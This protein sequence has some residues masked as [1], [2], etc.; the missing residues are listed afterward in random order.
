MSENIFEDIT[1][2]SRSNIM[3]K[4]IY[5]NCST[6]KTGLF[7]GARKK[8]KIGELINKCRIPRSEIMYA[9]QYRG[10]TRDNEGDIIR[11]IF[12]IDIKYTD[13]KPTREEIEKYEKY[14]RNKL[15]NIFVDGEI[16]VATNHR[17]N[18]ISFHY[19]VS[20]YRTTCRDLLNLCEEMEDDKIDKTI[21]KGANKLMRIANQYKLG[22]KG[23]PE[24]E[25]KLEKYILNYVEE[26]YKVYENKKEKEIKKKGNIIIKSNNEIKKDYKYFYD[27]REIEE[28]LDRL[29]KKYIEEFEEWFKI[30]GILKSENLYEIWNEWSKKSKCYDE[31]KN[32]KIWNSIKPNININHL[33]YINNKENG[34]SKNDFE[35]MKK[36]EPI[37]RKIECNIKE[38]EESKI[39]PD[40]FNK[41]ETIIM[42]SDT[43]TGKTTNFI[44]NYYMN[45]SNKYRLLSIVS[46][47]S[48]ADDQYRAFNDMIIDY[49]TG[50][51]I[52]IGAQHY[53]QT[54]REEIGK[55]LICQVDS[56]MKYFD[57]GD[58]E[59]IK[60]YV[61]YMDE[62]NS[63]ITYMIQS[64]TLKGKRMEIFS[65]LRYIIK[66]CYKVVGTDADI[67]DLVFEF[68]KIRKDEGKI[69]IINKYKNYKGLKAY[70]IE[71]EER[72]YE[73]IKKDIIEGKYFLMCFDSKKKQEIV[74]NKIM[75]EY[76]SI[77]KVD[78]VE[79]F[80][81]INS[82]TSYD[83][84]K[85]NTE[86]WKNKY[87][88]YS[89]SI[90]YGCDFNIEKAQNVYCIFTNNSINPLG[91][92]Q[93]MTRTRNINNVYYH[94]SDYKR[95]ENEYES[96]EECDKKIRENIEMHKMFLQE[97][98]S[99]TINKEERYEILESDYYEM[100]KIYMYQRDILETNYKR[101]FEE[102]LLKKGF[103]I[104]KNEECDK[105]II[106]NKEMKQEIN[107]IKNEI[108]EEKEELYKKYIEYEE[109]REISEKE[110]IY[111]E[112]Y[113]KK[114]KILN[115][116]KIILKENEIMRKYIINDGE[117]LN[118]I[119]GV[120]IFYTEEK[121]KNEIT[122]K[123]KVDFAV[124]MMNN[125]EK[126]III[127]REIEKASGINLYNIEK[128]K[129]RYNEKV[130]IKEEI[131]KQ[132]KEIYRDRS[133]EIKIGT[134]EEVCK[135]IYKT[136]NK[137]Y[138]NMI[139]KTKKQILVNK[140]IKHYNEYKINKETVKEMYGI[141]K[142]RFNIRNVDKTVIEFL[143]EDYSKYEIL[144]DFIDE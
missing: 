122:N 32:M 31:E 114:R 76:K 107:E 140:K 69:Y 143:D 55:V 5:Y 87:I 1:N 34:E 92:I 96:I 43:N 81:M 45:E 54:K 71:K 110:K 120:K 27:K 19:V 28:I 70:D 126:K 141:W 134:V 73:I 99:I 24:L 11:P 52:N 124:N 103:I 64:N 68:L 57:K 33:V 109:E 44:R 131:V 42:R 58:I 66:N 79:N 21:Y 29:P 106:V 41:Y 78:K 12:D 59:E 51:R 138:S 113:E 102:I 6:V 18:K 23:R 90:V 91:M 132:Y 72:L 135:L 101:H 112:K 62:I 129:E 137:I 3:D 49:K 75:K 38:I 139:D 60:D 16:N 118:H 116:D 94:F 133:R 84:S 22:T 100:Y 128:Q 36:Y 56:L 15:R 30:T 119:N 121:I 40:N 48:L 130:I 46:R 74:Y 17:E 53:N 97:I 115:I 37:M 9:E 93:Q 61:V 8:I 14:Y 86:N 25:N 39:D 88:F 65:L 144:D 26:E 47:V 117:F 142:Y 85:T 98:C 20:N 95:K 10:C 123:C 67:S 7:F 105:K 13:R 127:L 89:P 80:I 136:Y 104:E 83:K 108:E 2:K 82:D 50:E 77:K 125:I 111:F 63:L 4:E 35:R